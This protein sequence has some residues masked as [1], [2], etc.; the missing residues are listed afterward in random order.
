APIRCALAAAVMAVAFLCSVQLTPA[1][2]QL[3]TPEF[4]CQNTVAKQGRKLFRKTFKTLAKCEDKI[5]KGDLPVSTDCATEID[6][7]AKIS[8][9][10]A[11]YQQKLIDFCPDAVVA[12]LDFGGS[13]TRVIC[14]SA[15]TD[16]AAA[17]RS[18]PTARSAIHARQSI[19]VSRATNGNASGCWGNR[20][21]RKPRSAW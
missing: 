13:C 6:T 16:P 11:K 2:A 4:K 7:A 1:A 15:A 8:D 5:S 14:V 18:T 3:A 19:R 20:W 12:N 21:P 10:E 17:A 9:T